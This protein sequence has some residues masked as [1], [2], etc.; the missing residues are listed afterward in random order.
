[1]TQI[2]IYAVA[3]Q[4]DGEIALVYFLTHTEARAYLEST[5]GCEGSSVEEIDTYPGS[6][7][8]MKAYRRVMGR[9]EAPPARPKLVINPAVQN[10]CN[11]L[12]ER[13][14]EDWA[15][16]EEGGSGHDC[17]CALEGHIQDFLQSMRT[18]HN[19]ESF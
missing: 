19:I 14:K 10:L 13:F 7:T 18:L 6:P 12:E 2:L 15:E 16:L 17:A 11:V 5:E 4:D 3:N 9:D 1:M 8:Y